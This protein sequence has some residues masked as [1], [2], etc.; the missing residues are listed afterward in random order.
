MRCLNCHTVLAADDA[1]CVSCGAAVAPDPVAGTRIQ[2]APLDAK[3]RRA[4]V[5]KKSAKGIV[6]LLAGLVIIVIGGGMF[7]DARDNR[8]V[9][10]VLNTAEMIQAA[11][12]EALPGWVVYTSPDMPIDTGVQ[13][14]KLRSGQA[15]SKFCLVP[16][17]DQWLLVKVDARF[18]GRKLEGQLTT[19]DRVAF[20]KVLAKFPNQA[21]RLLPYELDAEYDIAGTARQNSI[22]GGFVA[23]FGVLCLVT[24]F[25]KLRSQPPAF[26]PVPKAR[27]I[28]PA[29]TSPITTSGI[30]A[31]ALPKP[32]PPPRS[33][34]IRCV[35]GMIWAV[36]I[37]LVAALITSLIATA[38]AGNDE[39]LR[40][41]LNEAAAKKFTVWLLLGSV[42]LAGS[43]TK[44]GWLPGT[45]K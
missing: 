19:V 43:L 41:Q 1:K 39:Q 34:F 6:A 28:L 24:G 13:Y 44:L 7:F 38:G 27:A 2:M 9:P 35:F 33:L 37:F 16:V 25:T 15:T 17:G 42:A 4:F 10:R 3:T 40:K 14:A 29:V 20:P 22:L 11:G 31:T 23:G 45:R 12:P 21:K 5:I 26:V 18:S 32:L 36:V 30:F 8:P